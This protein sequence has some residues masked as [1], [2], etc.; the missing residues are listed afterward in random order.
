M[1]RFFL[2]D[3]DLK[4]V[5]NLCYNLE[6]IIEKDKLSGKIILATHKPYRLLERVENE[7]R[8]NSLDCNIYLLDVDL[9]SAMT[10]LELARRI[11]LLDPVGYIVFVTGHVEY[12]MTVYRHFIKAFDYM[13]KPINY[14]E[15]ERVVR[16]IIDDYNSVINKIKEYLSTPVLLKCGYNSYSLKPDD[17][18]AIERTYRKTLIYTNESTYSTSYPI[19]KYEEEFCDNKTLIKAHRSYIINKNAIEKVDF[20]NM[21]I[22][23]KN[24]LRVPISRARKKEIKQV[25]K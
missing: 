25:F 18:L 15:F 21:E 2:C 5:Q 22:I 20:E 23:L 24:G 4:C 11:R 16:H 12:G 10:G 3:D 9:E 14:D 1:F 13:I 6:K 7:A 19:K 17:I 8:Y